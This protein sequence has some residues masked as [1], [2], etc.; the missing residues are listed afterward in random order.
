MRLEPAYT[1]KFKKDIKKLKKQGKD[2]SDS[3]YFKAV[4]R[5]ILSGKTLPKKYKLHPLKGNYKGRM[6]C[7]IEP[8]WLLIWKKDNNRIIFERTGS[9][10]ELFD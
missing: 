2:F 5:L 1:N 3:G 9:H 10:S 6:E 8:D 4:V 7:H